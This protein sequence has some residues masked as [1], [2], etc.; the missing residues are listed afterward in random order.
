MKTH[1]TFALIIA[2]LFGFGT[3]S[4]LF[5]QTSSTNTTMTRK[6]EVLG[7]AE[8][9]VI[10]D[11]IY[12]NVAL[13]EYFQDKDRT[14]KVAIETLEK[15]LQASVKSAGIPK[16][17][18]QIENVYGNRWHWQPDKKKPADFQESRRY[19]LKLSDLSKIDEIL[20]NVDGKGIEFVN[21]TRYD[22]SNMEAYRRD[23]KIK[24]LQAAKEKAD[25]L[26]QSIGE[27]T[28]G[29]LEVSEM[30]GSDGNYPIP[31]QAYAKSNVMMESGPAYDSSAEPIDFKK[32]KL[33]YEMRAVFAIK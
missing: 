33:R 16:E 13:R 23:L 28:G 8:T 3:A 11:Q 6:I 31:Y 7:S 20:N 1:K 14:K 18:F 10:P 24:A 27:Q 12:F 32:I 22:H 17:N 30:G 2:L 19:V 4:T 25:Y 5:A 9:E 21:I 15:Q 29:I 26:L